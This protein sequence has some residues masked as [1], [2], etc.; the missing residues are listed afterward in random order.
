M[1]WVWRGAARAMVQEEVSG[2]RRSL[3]SVLMRLMGSELQSFTQATRS[4]NQDKE[5]HFLWVA[6]RAEDV[7]KHARLSKTTNGHVLYYF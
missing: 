3:A 5:S 4:G 2:P 7:M 6:W 1:N